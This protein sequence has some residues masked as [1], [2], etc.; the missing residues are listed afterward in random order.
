MFVSHTRKEQLFELLVEIAVIIAYSHES[1]LDDVGHNHSVFGLTFYPYSMEFREM[2]HGKGRFLCV[3]DEICRI[4]SIF[5][6]E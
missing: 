4:M 5:T 6:A 2:L 3:F 1:V